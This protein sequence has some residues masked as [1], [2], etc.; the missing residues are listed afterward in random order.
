MVTWASAPEFPGLLVKMQIPRLQ[1]LT[2]LDGSSSNLNFTSCLKNHWSKWC[3]EVWH[4]VSWRILGVE[5]PHLWAA[6]YN[7]NNNENDN[8]TFALVSFSSYYC[9]LKTCPF[10]QRWSTDFQEFLLPITCSWD[11]LVPYGMLHLAQVV[12][13]ENSSGEN[14][15]CYS[16]GVHLGFW[17]PLIIGTA[18]HTLRAH[19][20]LTTD[21]SKLPPWSVLE[22]WALRSNSAPT[23]QVS[24]LVWREISI[25]FLPPT[26]IGCS[27][28]NAGASAG[29]PRIYI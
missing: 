18:R 15:C 12:L 5:V 21:H 1:N 24:A 9:V 23:F 22:N 25:W 2:L 11:P 7:N 13:R 19:S 6:Q 4:L 20:D 8:I 27:L 29:Y 14:C 16:H 28:M 3:R 26:L 10:E 17:W